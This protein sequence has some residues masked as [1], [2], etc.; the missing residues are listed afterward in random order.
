MHGELISNKWAF[1]VA[2]DVDTDDFCNFLL[3]LPIHMF[4]TR[5]ADDLLSFHLLAIHLFEASNSSL[6]ICIMLSRVFDTL[7]PT[8]KEKIIE[9]STEDNPNKTRRNVGFTTR[10]VTVAIGGKFYLFL[11][12]TNQIDLVLKD[13]LNANTD[14]RD[15][16][17]VN[18][19]TTMI[20]WL[21]RQKTL[22][23]NMEIKCPYYMSLR[24]GS[25]SLVLK[26]ILSNIKTFCASFVEK[27]YLNGSNLE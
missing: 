27:R 9:Y 7:C 5:V 20:G 22:I 17:F 14:D 2:T 8:W 4:G 21:Q 3:D 10:L 13:R 16:P 15:F 18:F 25:F 6:E 23:R 1:Y 19:A 26:W 11:F 24:W 12:A